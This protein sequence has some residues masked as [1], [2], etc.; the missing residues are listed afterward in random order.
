MKTIRASLRFLLFILIITLLFMV[1]GCVPLLERLKRFGLI[2]SDIDRNLIVTAAMKHLFRILLRGLGLKVNLRDGVQSDWQNSKILV[3]SNHVSY[4]DVVILA[5]ARPMTFVA[6]TEVGTWPVLGPLISRMG[7]IFVE[8]SDVQDRVRCVHEMRRRLSQQNICVFP[9]GTTTPFLKPDLSRWQ[10]GQISAAMGEGIRVVKVAI[11]Y[12]NQKEISWIDDME[13]LPHL[14]K[15]LKHPSIRVSVVLKELDKSRF[16][17][18][19]LRRLSHAICHEISSD[20][21]FTRGRMQ[22][23][24][25]PAIKKGWVETEVARSFS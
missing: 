6:K 7:T 5:A 10:S 18:E 19:S 2:P 1:A 11:V 4:L 17:S 14:W 25:Y 20:C 9:E 8:R 24:L 16:Q 3:L 21:Q 22:R 12:E 15:V 13:L 23:K